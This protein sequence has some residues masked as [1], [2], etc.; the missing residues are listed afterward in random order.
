MTFLVNNAFYEKEEILQETSPS[1]QNNFSTS[2]F[3]DVTYSIIDYVPA[4]FSKYVEYSYLTYLAKDGSSGDNTINLIF[5]LIYSDDGGNSWFDW[6]ENT[7]VFIGSDTSNI[8]NKGLFNIKFFLETAA[9]G[10]RSAWAGNR[11]LKLWGKKVSGDLRLH[12]LIEFRNETGQ[13]SGSHYYY[14]TVK[15]A[16]IKG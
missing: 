13:I 3:I 15:C 12:E 1:I 8:R 14:P 4:P 16:S 9:S 5:K 7:S 11:K 2:S 10:S 6:G